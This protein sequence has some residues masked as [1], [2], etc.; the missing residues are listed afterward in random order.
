MCTAINGEMFAQNFY[1]G[2][3]LK[4]RT[5]NQYCEETTIE[6]MVPFNKAVERK[7]LENIQ[8]KQRSK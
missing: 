4:N 6:S 7:K 3:N 2:P 5:A 1:S 8:K